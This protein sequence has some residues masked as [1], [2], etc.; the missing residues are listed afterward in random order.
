MAFIN[1]QD[2]DGNKGSLETGELGLDVRTNNEKVYV[3][4]TGA[5]S[6]KAL[7]W[8]S[9]VDEALA[10]ASMAAEDILTA[11]KTVDGT[12]SGLDADLL[13]GV[14]ANEYPSTNSPAFTGTPT[15]PTAPA[16][17]KTTQIATTAFVDNT[18][19]A[20][21][22]TPKYITLDN[23][24]LTT[25]DKYV[26][27]TGTYSSTVTLTIPVATS[28]IENMYSFIIKNE[29]NQILLIKFSNG[30]LFHHIEAGYHTCYSVID[31]TDE[32]GVASLYTRE[33]P[34]KISKNYMYFNSFGGFN[35]PNPTT[36]IKNFV[37]ISGNIWIMLTNYTTL[38]VYTLDS[39]Q[40]TYRSSYNPTDATYNRISSIWVQNA[41]TLGMGIYL[42]TSDSSY[43]RC[44]TLSG[45]TLTKGASVLTL[46]TTQGDYTSAVVEGLRLTDT[47]SIVEYG[48]GDS[49]SG[50]KVVSLS[51]TTYTAG[52]EVGETNY[53]KKF[54]KI[55][56]TQL[57]YIYS[58]S[59]AY[60]YQLW[61]ISGTSISKG[62]AVKYADTTIQTGYSDPSTA[63]DYEHEY[64][65]SNG[66]ARHV[67][68]DG[69]VA[70]M[71]NGFAIFT[72]STTLTLH[73]YIPSSDC[74]PA[75]GYAVN[76]DIYV[77]FGIQGSSKIWVVDATNIS[78]PTITST[79]TVDLVLSG[80]IGKKVLN[81]ESGNKFIDVEQFNITEGQ[82]EYS[83][84][85]TNTAVI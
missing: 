5:D 17:T 70:Y 11:L 30:D 19:G 12:G 37:N 29:T 23:Q 64:F 2:T 41:T 40:F 31:N 28:Y 77:L 82:M 34:T 43:I 1:K 22:D 61:T 9:D 76:D 27:V 32:Q 65:N 39:G 81:L 10:N 13:G 84:I 83:Q 20:P 16:G 59:P 14:P 55:S 44:V 4:I 7:A 67:R 25:D 33:N 75:H 63:F 74:L 78:A 26:I 6:G 50:F 62:T 45:Y 73:G 47:T 3:G 42:D 52:A 36:Y 79:Y 66:S 46:D 48:T 15:A 38:T 54:I 58:S 24:V 53:F 56:P 8:Q 72:E 85:F 80:S 71:N 18:I 57:L 60:Y 51:G 69:K 68:A 49:T 21:T 35:V